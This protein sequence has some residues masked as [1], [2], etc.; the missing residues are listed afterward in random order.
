MIHRLIRQQSVPAP[1]D[2]VWDY[3]ATPANLNEMTPPDMNFEII[4]GGEGKMFQGQLIEYLVQF[5]PM[6]KSRWLTE[7][8][9]VVEKAYFVDEQRIGPYSFWYHEHSFEAVENGT[10]VRD[11]VTYQ[12]SFG[13]LGE[14][15]HTLWVGRR[16]KSIFDYR[17]QKIN[18]LF[19][20]SNVNNK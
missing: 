6:I 14:L 15:V 8:A 18:Q 19:G 4:H 1:L 11:Q 10:L 5:I 16:L 12:L 20:S 9:H 17:Q 13:P 3:F 2:V 7:I